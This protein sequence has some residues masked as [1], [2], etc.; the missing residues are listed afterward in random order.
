M[1]CIKCGKKLEDY[2]KFC[3]NCGNKVEEV[4]PEEKKQNKETLDYKEIEY[5]TLTLIIEEKHL[6]GKAV[7]QIIKYN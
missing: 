3:V 1:Y 4:L 7:E 5:N 6:D 2:A